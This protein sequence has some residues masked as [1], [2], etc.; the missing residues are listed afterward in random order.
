MRPFRFIKA[1]PVATVVLLAT[2]YMVVP[3]TLGKVQG[4]TGIGVNLPQP[5]AS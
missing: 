5:G 4:T 1:H 3:W 2:G